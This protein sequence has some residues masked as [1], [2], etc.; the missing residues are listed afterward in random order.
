[1]GAQELDSR[2]SVLEKAHYTTLAD[3][4][5]RFLRF[6]ETRWHEDVILR[7]EIIRS[8]IAVSIHLS[9]LAFPSP[10]RGTSKTSTHLSEDTYGLQVRL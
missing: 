1:M 3:A 5:R 8:G 2:A 7:I 6:S 10:C 9:L 4:S